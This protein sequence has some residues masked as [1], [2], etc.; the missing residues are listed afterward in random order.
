MSQIEQQISLNRNRTQQS[1]GAGSQGRLLVEVACDDRR[2]QLDFEGHE[3][4]AEVK[5]RALGE[6]QILSANPNKY[7]VIGANRQPLD[8]RQVLRDILAQG[9]SLEFRLIP[10]VAFGPVCSEK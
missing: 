9:Q 1:S 4:V 2:V 7:I 5:R 6:M 3:T 8:D 10:Q